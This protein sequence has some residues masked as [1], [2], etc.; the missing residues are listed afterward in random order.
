MFSTLEKYIPPPLLYFVLIAL[1]WYQLSN[2]LAN[3][4]KFV[5]AVYS[6]VFR[7]GLPITILSLALLE[8][9][10]RR[11]AIAPLLRGRDGILSI[12]AWLLVLSAAVIITEFALD[13]K[14]R[15]EVRQV[16]STPIPTQAVPGAQRVELR[17]NVTSASGNNFK[18]FCIPYG[19]MSDNHFD[20]DAPAARR[21]EGSSIQLITGSYR[22]VAVNVDNPS[23]FDEID[24]V[25]DG[26]ARS[27]LTI[28]LKIPTEEETKN[29]TEG[30]VKIG[31][32][33]FKRGNNKAAP[34]G[35]DRGPERDIYLRGFYIDK[36]ETSNAQ[37][38]AFVQSTD[39]PPPDYWLPDRSGYKKPG[40][41]KPVVALNWYDAL[42]YARF[43]HKR[44]PLESEWERA[45][46]DDGYKVY[47]WGD[48]Y[49]DLYVTTR[50]NKDAEVRLAQPHE[51]IGVVRIQ[52]LTDDLNISD[53]TSS[54]IIG[55]AGNAREWCFEL[56]RKSYKT[57]TT[58]EGFLELRVIRG[59]FVSA[60]NLDPKLAARAD[61]RDYGNPSKRYQSVGVRGV[62][63]ITYDWLLKDAEALLT[64]GF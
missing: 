30:M 33:V 1:G 8:L 47:P 43:R 42:N 34:L 23:L 46:H 45:A 53:Q 24:L 14:H 32:G 16:S 10:S 51:L 35:S 7:Y 25:V 20:L 48:E 44:L 27:P 50:S 40:E 41:N 29:I 52:E 62:R 17:L 21:I 49:D 58:E 19:W 11:L 36:Y 38:A 39:Y 54:G 60:T 61:F 26:L 6:P 31:N 9:R 37:Y 55:M 2:A 28:D 59:S 12:L 3:D 56:Y 63:S 5:M 18:V 4:Q 15:Y 22:L 13:I 57:K 64:V